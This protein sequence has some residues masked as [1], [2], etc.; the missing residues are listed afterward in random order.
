MK[1]L[2]VFLPMLL[3]LGIALTAHAWQTNGV[4]PGGAGSA[5]P[6][7]VGSTT[8]VAV[9]TCAAG[10]RL[11]VDFQ[12]KGGTAN[13]DGCFM[14]MAAAASPCAA[15]SPAPNSSTGVGYWLASG[16][17]GYQHTTINYLEAGGMPAL[18]AELDVVCT[19]AETVGYTVIP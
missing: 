13:T 5:T 1:R 7:S 16:G 2:I 12:V 17:S 4:A 14:T 6:V 3:L 9:A 11:Y 19:G 18:N 10:N 8:P 15:A